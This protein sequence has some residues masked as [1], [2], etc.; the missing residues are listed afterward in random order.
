M[1]KK[2]FIVLCFGL[3]L[4]SCTKKDIDIKQSDNEDLTNILTGFT[5]NEN[6]YANPNSIIS[7]DELNKIINKNKVKVVGI[8][9]KECMEKYIPSSTLISIDDITTKVDGVS[10]MLVD[11]KRIERVLSNLGIY[12][13]DTVIIYDNNDSLYA[14]RLWWSMKVYGHD[15]IRILNG[16]LKDWI[17]SGYETIE[18][19]I[20]PPKSYYIAKD[21]NEKL[22][23]DLDYI[24]KISGSKDDIILDVRSKKEYKNG[25]IP[26]ATWIEWTEALNKDSKFKNANELRSI[27]E[28]KDIK[29]KKSIVTQCK[30]AKR[31][32]HTYFV[33]NQ[34]LGYDNVKVYDGSWVEYSQSGE[35]IEK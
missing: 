1:S 35:P 21:K 13:G 5:K 30:T 17:S 33:L 18:N 9:D 4:L 15:D 12:N 28:T 11:K 7:S 10:G 23:A 29:D 27:Y 14:T 34:L 6:G 26:G 2:F 19:P 25:H 8:I 20:V 3:L 22:I 16:G 24:K 32:A 31:A